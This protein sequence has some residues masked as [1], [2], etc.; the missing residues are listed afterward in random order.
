MPPEKFS[1]NMVR[2]KAIRKKKPI[3]I[4]PLKR[5]FKRTFRKKKALK[6]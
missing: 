4:M 5:T 6:I 1:Q 2:K 3:K